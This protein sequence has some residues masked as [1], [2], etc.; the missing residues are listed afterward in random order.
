[1]DTLNYGKNNFYEMTYLII[2]KTPCHHC[3]LMRETKKNAFLHQWV[4]ETGKEEI[5]EDSIAKYS[6][7]E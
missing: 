5:L 3:G 2:K 1:M 6:D 7:S 4:F